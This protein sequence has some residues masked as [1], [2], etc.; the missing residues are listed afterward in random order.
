MVIFEIFLSVWRPLPEI[1]GGMLLWGPAGCQPYGLMCTNFST[2][3]IRGF[4]MNAS[5]R[6]LRLVHPFCLCVL[7]FVL[8]SVLKNFHSQ[9]GFPDQP[10][11][12]AFAAANSSNATASHTRS[13]ETG[14]HPPRVPGATKKSSRG[15]STEGRLTTRSVYQQNKTASLGT[16]SKTTADDG[17]PTTKWPRQ[18]RPAAGARWAG[19]ASTYTARH[20]GS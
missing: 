3:Y 18:P 17:S 20:T 11:C 16:T 1:L 7:N 14:N 15:R 6:A 9:H 13:T 12:W 2:N 8:Q 4:L 19:P 10:N 5:K